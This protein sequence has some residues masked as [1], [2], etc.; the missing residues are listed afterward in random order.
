LL[1]AGDELFHYRVML[2]RYTT[3]F[4]NEDGG[5]QTAALMARWGRATD[6]EWVYQVRMRNGKII[7]EIYQGVQHETKDF[8]GA[9]AGG[10]HPLLAVASDNSTNSVGGI[11]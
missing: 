8:T 10:N 11:S 4:T 6:I 5:T 1:W 9:R 2:G 3:I 7:E